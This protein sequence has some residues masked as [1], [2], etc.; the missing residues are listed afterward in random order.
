MFC[1]LSPQE[2]ETVT[3]EAEYIFF[4]F[5][6]KGTRKHQ[7]QSRIVDCCAF[8]QKEQEHIMVKAECMYFLFP[9]AKGA[10]KHHFL[11]RMQLVCV[12]FHKGNKKTSLPKPNA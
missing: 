7:F 8:S 4:L 9:V 5:L 1:F 6:A 11:G 12:P 2:R 3:F 10:R